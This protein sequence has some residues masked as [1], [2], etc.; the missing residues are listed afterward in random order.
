MALF[1]V[2]ILSPGDIV[3]KYTYWNTFTTHT[4]TTEVQ[5]HWFVLLYQ[6]QP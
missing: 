3:K 5:K 6:I 1:S 2:L 4:E